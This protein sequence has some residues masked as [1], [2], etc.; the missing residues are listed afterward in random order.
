MMPLEYVDI[1]QK[2]RFCKIPVGIMV[3]FSV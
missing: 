3:K 2:L 1:I